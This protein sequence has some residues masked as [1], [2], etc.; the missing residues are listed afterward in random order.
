MV[1]TP[2]LICQKDTVYVTQ[3]PLYITGEFHAFTVILIYYF[4]ECPP[5]TV[6][7]FFSQLVEVEDIEL[8]QNKQSAE[9]FEE[10]I[11]EEIIDEKNRRKNLMTAF[12]T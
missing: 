8:F 9:Y 7:L 6:S 4:C 11:K 10:N 1:A 12:E 2:A 5:I 3:T